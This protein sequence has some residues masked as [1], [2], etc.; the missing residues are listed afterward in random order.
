[1]QNTAPPAELVDPLPK[2]TKEVVDA[3]KN[4]VPPNEKSMSLKEAVDQSAKEKATKVETPTGP[5]YRGIF[6]TTRTIV[7][8][9]GT[10]ALFQGLTAGLHRQIIFTGIRVGSYE[11]VRDYICG[12]LKPGENPALY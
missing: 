2:V 9:E 1:M 7:A 10:R 3:I 11:H 4:G 6:G 8:E 5:K 12:E